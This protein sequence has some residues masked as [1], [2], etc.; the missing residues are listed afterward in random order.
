MQDS[1]S[2]K[3]LFVAHCVLNQNV[4]ASG[5]VKKGY[6][7]VVWDLTELAKK[8]DIGLEQL[9]CPEFSFAGER[10]PM[11]YTQCEKISG[12]R[13]HCSNLAKEVA[14][15][16]AELQKCGYEVLGIVGIARSPTCSASDVYVGKTQAERKLAK[17]TGI[18]IQELKK[19][20]KIP[21]VDFDYRKGQK[22]L[23]SIESLLK[24]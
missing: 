22:S 19:L 24:G 11:T 13:T 10:E 8:Y 5:L 20:V 17:R 9:P 6:T 16:I 23:H 21:I 15:F 18:F 1:R 14:D 7:S 3:I 12:F 4:I 2:R